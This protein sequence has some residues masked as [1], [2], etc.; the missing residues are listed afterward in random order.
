MKYKFQYR[1]YKHHL[2]R[3]A[4]RA[5]KKAADTWMGLLGFGR[6][7]GWTDGRRFHLFAKYRNNFKISKKVF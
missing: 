4:A 1:I 7:D 5:I 6:M 3:S 2:A